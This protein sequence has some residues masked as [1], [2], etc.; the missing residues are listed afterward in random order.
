MAVELETVQ[1]DRVDCVFE[2]EDVVPHYNYRIPSREA[3]GSS[4]LEVF[5]EEETDLAAAGGELEAPASRKT[6]SVSSPSRGGSTGSTSS[7][8]LK[9]N[10]LPGIF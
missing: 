4:T 9:Y 5:V 10:S 8:G 1:W 2:E 6:S 3:L 7:L